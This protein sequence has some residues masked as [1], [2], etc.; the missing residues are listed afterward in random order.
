MQRSISYVSK[1]TQGL[2]TNGQDN[3]ILFL[4][5]VKLNFGNN[6]K[7]FCNL[8]GNVSPMNC[9]GKLLLSKFFKK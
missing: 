5:C 7:Q 3:Y 4:L 6:H 8:S 2:Y 9:L 1:L